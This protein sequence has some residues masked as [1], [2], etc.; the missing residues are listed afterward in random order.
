MN[1]CVQCVQHHECVSKRGT[2]GRQ[3]I[4]LIRLQPE[5]DAKPVQRR[6]IASEEEQK[7]QMNANYTRTRLIYWFASIISR[8]LAITDVSILLLMLSNIHQYNNFFLKEKKMLKKMLWF[9]YSS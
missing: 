2:V 4:Y 8:C 5:D 7:L 9:I 1:V 6:R 3:I